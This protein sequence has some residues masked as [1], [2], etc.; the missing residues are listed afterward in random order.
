MNIR[1]YHDSDTRPVGDYDYCEFA[2]ITDTHLFVITQTGVRL[3][4]NLRY[5]ITLADG[6]AIA[7]NTEQPGMLQV[8][9]SAK[10]KKLKDSES[11]VTKNVKSTKSITKQESTILQTVPRTAEH[12]GA[13]SDEVYR[14]RSR[15]SSNTERNRGDKSGTLPF[16]AAGQD[17][18]F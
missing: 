11:K 2:G 7:E 16:E 15:R 10:P 4:T 8:H 6:D 3:L 9:G 1:L 13:D 5:K 17:E 14:P 12:V 18:D